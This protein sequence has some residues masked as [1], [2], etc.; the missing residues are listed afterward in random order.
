MDQET[1]MSHDENVK[2]KL[3]W[4]VDDPGVGVDREK[5]ELLKRAHVSAGQHLLCDIASQLPSHI[6]WLSPRFLSKLLLLSP[7]TVSCACPL[8]GLVPGSYPS[9]RGSIFRHGQSSWSVVCGIS[10]FFKHDLFSCQTTKE[11][12]SCSSDFVSVWRNC[13]KLFIVPLVRTIVCLFSVLRML[14]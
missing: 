1:K 10:S 14:H 7:A 9:E 11:Q 4:I 3:Q 13:Y 8:L 6:F 5:Y 2:N 12:S